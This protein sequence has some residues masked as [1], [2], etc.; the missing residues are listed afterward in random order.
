VHPEDA[1]RILWPPEFLEPEI[2][3]GYVIEKVLQD[4]LAFGQEHLNKG[5]R[6]EEADLSIHCFC[7]PLRRVRES[8]RARPGQTATHPL[9]IIELMAPGTGER[10]GAQDDVIGAP[11]HCL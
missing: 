11:G 7:L 3:Q 4:L 5:F 6:D 2:Y 10:L 1:D 8:Q 9:A